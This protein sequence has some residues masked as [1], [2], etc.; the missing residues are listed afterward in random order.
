MKK[1]PIAHSNRHR[2]SARIAIP[3]LMLL[4][5]SCA[6]GSLTLQI[7]NTGA[8]PAVPTPLLPLAGDLLETSVSSFSGENAAAEVRNG[9]IYDVP[10][11]NTVGGSFPA[12]VWNEPVT[13]YNFDLSTNMLGYE[14]T[15]IQAYSAW[16]D[17]ASQSYS[18]FYAQVGAPTTFFQLGSAIQVLDGSQTSII[19]R[20]EDSVSGVP[21]LSNV[22]SIRFVQNAVLPGDPLAGVN[23]VYREL[24]VVGFASVPEP[25]T[26][27]LGLCGALVLFRRRRA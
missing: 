15:L 13:T 4:A 26:S 10:D 22:S 14:I 24:D 11:G 23:T 9:A 2:T 27:V 3:A 12:Q 18:I 8:N 7:Q 1:N 20:S 6:H 16:N 25:T 5:V 17:R 21:I 19:T